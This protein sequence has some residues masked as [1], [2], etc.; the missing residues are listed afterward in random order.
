MKK[1][2]RAFTLI[3]LLVVVLII[4]ILAAV[5]LPQYQKAVKKARLTEWATT[6]NALTK[7]IDVYILANGYPNELVYFLGDK[8]GDYNYADLDID[9]PW[10]KH[11]GPNNSANKIGSW[12][13][14]CY[15]DENDGQQCYIC[16]DTAQSTQ[17][18]DWLG[19]LTLCVE[20]Y[21]NNNQWNLWANGTN[22]DM[23]LV[24][25]W[26]ATHYGVSRMSDNAKTACAALG[27]E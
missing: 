14:A 18:I 27:I 1:S 8:T 22:E 19:R 13:S 24:C 15:N 25:Q 6:V 21:A 9:I 12:N 16:V 17:N 11:L 5:A 20:T 23:K 10:E 7:A 26:W 3:E 4:G 2:C